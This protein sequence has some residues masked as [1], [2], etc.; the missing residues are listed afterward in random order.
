MLSYQPLYNVQ[1]VTVALGSRL[2]YLLSFECM[3]CK[4]KCRNYASAIDK[5]ENTAEHLSKFGWN[6]GRRGPVVLWRKHYF[7]FVASTELHMLKEDVRLNAE[8]WP[9]E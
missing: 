4:R 2:L 5:K 8:I 3:M 6:F 1:S 7:F 9:S